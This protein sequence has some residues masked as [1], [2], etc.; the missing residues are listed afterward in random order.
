MKAD[1][2][3]LLLEMQKETGKALLLGKT[4]RP[5]SREVAEALG[6][7]AKRAAYIF[8]KWSNRGWYDYGVSVATGWLT[9]VGRGVKA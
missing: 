3:V 7:N 4:L 1:E 6:M 2:K 8:R 9:K 5:C